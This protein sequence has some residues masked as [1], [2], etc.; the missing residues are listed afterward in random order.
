MI[1]RFNWLIVLLV[2]T[3]FAWIAASIVTSIAAHILFEIPTPQGKIDFGT[4]GNKKASRGKTEYDVII[5]RDLLQVEKKAATA[6]QAPVEKDVVRPIAEMGLTLRGTIAGPKEVARAII[7]EKNQQKSYKIGDEVKGATVLAIYRNKVIMDV[8]G[9]EQMLVVKETDTKSR[10]SSRSTPSRPSQRPSPT[11][12]SGLTS[13]MQNL[14]QY[15]GSARVVPYFKGGEPYGFRVSNLKEDAMIYEIGV[16]SGDIIR[17]VNGIPIRT[18]E[19]AFNVYQELQNES[20]VEVEL[21]RQ[22]ETT[23]ISVPLQ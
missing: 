3:I 2:L 15:I 7:E 13:I 8:N 16:R 22:G 19:D 12:S 1:K 23:T 20:T 5:E 14:D 11:S 21:E 6:K 4:P 18:P 9:Q 10:V 17:S